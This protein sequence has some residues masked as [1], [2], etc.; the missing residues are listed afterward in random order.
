MLSIQI[1]SKWLIE[2]KQIS[3]EFM[4]TMKNNFKIGN[5][6]LIIGLI[7]SAILIIA[8]NILVNFF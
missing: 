6:L 2:T 3:K 7:L 8:A 5:K 4:K 1:S